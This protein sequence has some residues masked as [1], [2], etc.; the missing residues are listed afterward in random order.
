M[1]RRTSPSAGRFLPGSSPRLSL[2]MPRIARSSRAA[3]GCEVG[4]STSAARCAN[5]IAASRRPIVARPSGTG[6][7]RGS[8]VPRFVRREFLRTEP[9]L[10]E[11]RQER[12]DRRRRRGKRAIAALLAPSAEQPPVRLVGAQRRVGR[13]PAD[14][15]VDA[16]AIARAQA[17]GDRVRA[18]EPDR[19]PPARQPRSDQIRGSTRAASSMLSSSATPTSCAACSSNRT[20]E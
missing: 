17:A 16:L 6:S 10:G 20:G 13:R 19:R 18:T 7:L 2:R 11:Q 14:I 1:S 5:T 3:S 15:V 8:T 12:G 4:G 9:A